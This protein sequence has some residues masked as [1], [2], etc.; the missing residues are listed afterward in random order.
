MLKKFLIALSL[1]NLCFYNVINAFFYKNFFYVRHLPSVK[2]YLALIINELLIAAL[3]LGIWEC[4]TRLNNKF[5]IKTAKVLFILL[6]LTAV[7]ETVRDINQINFKVFKNCLLIIVII[8]LSFKKL[9]KATIVFVLLSVPY[10]GVI[11]FQSLM[12]IITTWNKVEPFQIGQTLLATNN[13]TP[14]VVWVIFDEMDFQ[15]AFSERVSGLKLPTFDRFIDQ[16]IFAENAF[17][18]SNKTALSLP[19]LIDGRVISRVSEI[20]NDKLQITYQDTDETVEWGSRPNVFSRAR[21]LGLN[22]ALIGEYL[23]YSR[24]IGK[25]L[26][27]CNWY[28]FYPDYVSPVDT[29]SANIW[30]QLL[31]TFLGPAKNYIQRKNAFSKI[32]DNSLSLVTDPS[33]NLVMIHFPVPH[34]PHFYKTPWWERSARGYLNSLTLA[35]ETLKQLWNALDNKNLWDNTTVIVTSDHWLREHKKYFDFKENDFRIPFIVKLAN[36]KDHISYKH[37]F[38]TFNT[39]EL[40]L[41]ILRKEII[42]PEDVVKWLDKNKLNPQ[43]IQ[44]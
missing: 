24:L 20:G 31:F 9:T 18:P 11:F 33:Y 22:S 29:L 12:G 1:T 41:A 5:L 39:Q 25:D 19:A 2:S 16:S 44:I 3:L 36:Q 15:I 14:R 34:G 28:S 37:A 38:N 13:S 21:T 6:V 32:L 4:I 35:D 8:L 27:Y 43:I 30:S 17:P 40:V 7:H 26:S 10:I 23:P 42:K